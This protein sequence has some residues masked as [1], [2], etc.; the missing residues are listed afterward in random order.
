MKERL[1][2]ESDGYAML[3]CERCGNQAVYDTLRNTFYC[4]ICD[5]DVEV[6]E[7]EVSY[8]F[9]LLLDELKSMCIYPKLV[10]GDRA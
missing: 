2:D 5:R 10:L 6:A 1:L 7:V 9:K 4:S 8:A 3:V